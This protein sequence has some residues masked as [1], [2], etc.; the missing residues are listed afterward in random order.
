MPAANQLAKAG[1][2]RPGVPGIA[3]S[4]GSLM[5]DTHTTVVAN[6]P[7]TR[8]HTRRGEKRPLRSTS[9]IRTGSTA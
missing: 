3:A 6:R 9:H 8:S 7:T 4:R 2:Q 5:K 1:S